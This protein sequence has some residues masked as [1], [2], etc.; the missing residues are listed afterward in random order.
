MAITACA[1]KFLQQLDLLVGERAH[2]LTVDDDDA[3][4]FVIFQHRYREMCSRAGKFVRGGLGLSD[5]LIVIGNVDRP[6]WSARHDATM[7]GRRSADRP[8]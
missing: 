8:R 1:A 5:S 4:Q 7:A 3:D 6:A 2:L